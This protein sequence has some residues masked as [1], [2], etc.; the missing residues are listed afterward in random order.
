[1]PSYLLD[2]DYYHGRKSKLHPPEGRRYKPRKCGDPSWIEEQRDHRALW[3]LLLYFDLVWISKSSHGDANK[4]WKLLTSGG[5][6]GAWFRLPKWELDEMDCVY[7]FLPKSSGVKIPSSGQSSHQSQLPATEPDSITVPQPIPIYN[8]TLHKW[9]QDTL[10]LN[11]MNAV[12]NYFEILQ[13]IWH[14][15]L[16]RSSIKPFQHL[17]FVIWDFEK[18]VRLGLANLSPVHQPPWKSVIYWVRP[19]KRNTCGY[20]MW[21]RWRSVVS[22]DFNGHDAQ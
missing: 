4:V 17:G 22:E 6:H 8:D 14:S 18:M 11:Q 21:F 19:F 12:A 1:M 13:I 15:P 20:D 16:Y 2:Q 7:E 9:Q 10:I 3:R 5:P